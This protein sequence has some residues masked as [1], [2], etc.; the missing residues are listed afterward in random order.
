VRDRKLPAARVLDDLRGRLIV[1]CQPVPGGALD[2]PQFVVA[3]GRAA[4]DGGAAGL[5]IE[6]LENMRVMRAATQVPIIGLVK[7]M[8]PGH[9]AYIT[10]CTADVADLA[11]AGAD[12][13]AFDATRRSRVT[14]VRDLVAACQ[15]HG[16]IA[17]ADIADEEDAGQAIAAGADILA[18]TLSGYT[19]AVTPGDPDL[20][21]ISTCARLARPVLAEGRIR[22]PL[23]HGSDRPSAC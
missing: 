7:R 9:A 13:V 2:A 5:R 21:L 19:G 3:L 20:P 8:E 18:T 23:R 1:S 22:T 10:P 15:D 17:M 12:I 14:A 11:R 16:V 4:L 6:G